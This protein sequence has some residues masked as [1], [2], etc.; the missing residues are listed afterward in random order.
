MEFNPYKGKHIQAL[1]NAS[2]VNL[3]LAHHNSGFDAVSCP[4][5]AP[6]VTSA[7]G[8]NAHKYPFEYN[9]TNQMYQQKRC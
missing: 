8:V 2:N 5:F 6:A 4:G 1:H 9:G 7:S 3:D